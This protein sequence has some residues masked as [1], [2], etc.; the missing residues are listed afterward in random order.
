MKGLLSIFILILSISSEI[1]TSQPECDLCL[2]IVEAVETFIDNGDTVDQ[3]IDQ[4]NNICESLGIFESICNGIV[5]DKINQIID[6]IL[7]NN[8]PFSICK[9]FGFCDDP[10]T[11]TTAPPPPSMYIFPHK[12]LT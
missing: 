9:G 11:T 1:N 8:P 12:C 7:D 10:D 6:D 4:V 2:T 3:I 5:E